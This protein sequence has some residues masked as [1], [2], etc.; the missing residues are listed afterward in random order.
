[1]QATVS[2]NILIIPDNAGSTSFAALIIIAV[3]IFA[4]YE[5]ITIAWQGRRYRKLKKISEDMEE[6]RKAEEYFNKHFGGNS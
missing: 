2:G 4:A 6:E 1:M 3:I 5:I